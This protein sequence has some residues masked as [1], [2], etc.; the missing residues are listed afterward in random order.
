M[1]GSFAPISGQSGGCSVTLA[2]VLLATGA[3]FI[4]WAIHS[5]WVNTESAFGM[6]ADIVFAQ[7]W[8]AA[9]L[10]FGLSVL[11]HPTLHW[12]ERSPPSSD[13]RCWTSL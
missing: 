11:A 13:A 4:G 1:C 5:Y 6:A 8:F 2:L 12:A 3:G 9:A 7:W 10:L